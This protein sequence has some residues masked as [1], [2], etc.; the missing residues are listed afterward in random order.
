MKKF[1][2]NTSIF[3]VP[4]L[5]LYTINV[6]NFDQRGAEGDLA[7]M[8]YFYSNPSP[9]SLINNQYNLPKQYTLLSE[10]KPSSKV[11][12]DVMTIGDSFSEQES[13]GYKN[14]LANMGPSVIHVDRTISGRNPIQTL[15]SLM[16]SDLF[17]F[18]KPDFV[19]VQSIERDIN[20]RTQS[21][22]F[23]ARLE[24]IDFY[25]PTTSE[26]ISVDDTANENN[27]QTTNLQFFSDATLK[28]PL[29]FLQYLFLDKP[30]TSNTYKVEATR[31]D[32]F[33]N[34]PG[35]L[36]FYKND[37]RK[38]E[39]KNDSL[40]T[41]NS[42]KVLNELAS[43][44][45]QKNIELIV[46]ISPDKFDLYYS[47]IKEKSNFMKPTFFSTY[48]HAE[49]KYK[50][51]DTYRVLSGKIT[52]ERDVYYYDDTHWSPKG[53][54]FVAEEIYSLMGKEKREDEH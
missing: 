43:L 15:V 21:I 3:V 8:G 20:S 39:A 14:F 17:E 51:V 41:L 6:F 52:E 46:L 16:N 2:L 44:L 29:N 12:V 47:Y 24:S 7:R 50:N 54:K 32:L 11:K 5:I 34:D 13:L 48:E 33:T 30:L 9:S 35:N 49:K 28:M 25:K 1:I 40:R 23:D 53:A 31:K 22:D 37:L 26:E 19:V 4:F 10:I 27:I 36:L 18:V 42:I 38:L 45:S